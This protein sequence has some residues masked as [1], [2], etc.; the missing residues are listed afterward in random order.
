MKITHIAIAGF[1]SFKDDAVLE[2]PQ[3][4]G[5][6]QLTGVNE[7]E[8]ALGANGS[9][10][11]TVWDAVVWCLFG[12]TARGL[13]GSSVVNWEGSHQCSVLLMV[14]IRGTTYEIRRTR[15]PN[16]LVV[17]NVTLATEPKK[18]TDEEVV[19]LVG[20]NHSTF[21]LTALMGQFGEFFLDMSPSAQMGVFVEALGLEVCDAA[22]AEARKQAKEQGR[23][24]EQLNGAIAQTDGSVS[25]LRRH[26][27]EIE[28]SRKSW[29]AERESKLARLK[30]R[31]S[32]EA[33]ELA[34]LEDDIYDCKVKLGEKREIA[35]AAEKKVKTFTRKL[36]EAKDQRR[37]V[38]SDL[39]IAQREGT[40]AAK[41]LTRLRKLVDAGVCPECGQEV[42]TAVDGPIK[43]AEAALAAAN[44]REEE[45]GERVQKIL[46]RIKKIEDRLNAASEIAHKRASSV[47][48]LNE[49]IARRRRQIEATTTGIDQLDERIE[50][51]E[52]AACPYDAQLERARKDIEEGE[53]RLARQQAEHRVQAEELALTQYW[54][55][56]FMVYRLW[57]VDRALDLLA[58]EVNNSLTELGL[59][60]WSVE[61]SVE[62]E[63][64]GGG[65]KQQFSTLIKSPYSDGPVS[66]QAWSGGETQRLRIAGAIGMAN[67]IRRETGFNPNIEVWDEPTAHLGESGVRDL[68]AFF[69]ARS[70]DAGRQI[71]IVDHRSID[72]GTFDSVA[73][74]VKTPTGSR[75][76]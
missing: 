15:D 52:N 9:G 34:R 33:E 55:E 10:K 59:H 28:Q 5:L 65:V 75:I 13:R 11:S 24:I 37:D 44:E 3:G 8:P 72:N 18:C 6:H 32:T 26:T 23:S 73:T 61:F 14:E 39:K 64:A 38:A 19:E 70:T 48:K 69:A 1:K 76:E 66:W 4:E 35:E 17:T 27:V 12:K 36:D 63:K 22:V 29:E 46:N 25:Q 71:W 16:T 20:A 49:V 43:A 2:L 51:A 74:V 21:L 7:V 42:G 53:A 67:L 60:G 47:T 58:I 45:V 57:R 50:E 30:E 62:R 56:G 54:T 31:R 40:S 68:I 41:E